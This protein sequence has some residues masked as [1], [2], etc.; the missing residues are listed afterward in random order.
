MCQS[1]MSAK[2][3]VCGVNI[4]YYLKHSTGKRHTPFLEWTRPCSSPKSKFT[5]V[6]FLDEEEFAS[7][8][9]TYDE[10]SVEAAAEL[11]LMVSAW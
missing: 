10:N 6:E 2:V 3:T 5:I 7:E 8:N 4:R 11:G 9:I 1:F